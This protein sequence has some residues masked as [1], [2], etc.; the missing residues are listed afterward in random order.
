MKKKFP[1]FHQYDFMDCGPTSLKMVCKFHGK[2]VDLAYLREISFINGQG[3][4]F[5]GL[6]D[7]AEKLGLA[8]MG[9]SVTFNDLAEELS[10]PCIVHWRQ[11][12]Y[13][14]V[15]KI[16]NNKV[17]VGDPAN[18][19]LIT[20]S[21]KD[22][23]KGWL[24][25]KNINE[26][27]EGLL[28]TL[29]PT[30]LFYESDNNSTT[31][32][33]LL[34]FLNK[35]FKPHQKY[36]AQVLLGLLFGT[37]LQLIF[38]FLTQQIVDTGINTRNI[39]FIYLILIAQIVLFISQSALNITRNWI[40]LHVT[41]RMNL[42]MLSDFIIKLMKLPIIYFDSRATGDILQRINDNNRIQT[43]LST[44]T[45]DVLFS[46][47]TLVVFSFILAYFNLFLF[48]V[49]IIGSAFYIVWILLFMK[50]RAEMDF[51][52]FDQAASNQNTT[53]QLIDGMQEI[54]LNG[55]EKRR[56]WDWEALQTRLFKLNIKNLVLTQ[57]Q[58][59]GGKFID[60]LKNII[61][62]FIA[63]KAV[64]D[65]QMT[66]GTMLSVQYIIGQM[67]VPINNFL[68]F[69]R[70]Y[71]DAKL[72][73][74]RLSEIHNKA[75]EEPLETE[76]INEFTGDKSIRI[77]NLNFRYGSSASEMVLKNIN[78][79]LPEGKVTAIVGSSGSGKTTLLKLL[80]KF[81]EPTSGSIYV[82]NTNLKSFGFNFWRANC[83]AVMQDGY[84]FAD[85]ISRNISESDINGMIDKKKLML[86]SEIANIAEFIEDLPNGYKTKI[87]SSGI[88]ISGGQKQRI[89][90]A[91]AVYKN[92]EYIF[93]DEATS[94]L[95]ANNETV[96]MRNL[97][98]FFKNG[99][100]GNKT[101]VVI[102]HRLSTVK[103]AD[104]II[105]LNKGEIVESGNHNELVVKKG[106]YYG[107]VKN[108]L[109]L[110]D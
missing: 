78:I 41:S 61:I 56:R 23:L 53:I 64:I 84:I 18:F 66:L 46:T 63:A 32:T 52:Y 13:A 92:P 74:L 6:V 33:N 83:G 79:I 108:Q 45:L 12:H 109:E 35:Y 28:L 4:T 55:S 93:F 89:L 94:S 34:S 21:K 20:Y 7:A 19:D 14:V 54:K 5:A 76:F 110:G 11:R 82:G 37:F 72:S 48:I 98:N 67:N 15:Y 22:F 47:L 69:I 27:S 65:G 36:I 86:A 3:T 81:N 70:N 106:F 58:N 1:H 31:K 107:L 25:S 88:G 44:T 49:F 103:K 16:S 50:R 60:Q 30:P 100:K 95:D 99:S 87:G 26:D 8:T 40:V 38:P 102:A 96:I 24:S 17:I 57:T 2:N 51:R 85:S 62:S 42:R 75:D 105:V 59:E 101:V 90:I 10:L 68:G 77:E 29:E 9:L 39:N 80:L 71:Q 97:D 91:R 73:L 43:F 104:Q